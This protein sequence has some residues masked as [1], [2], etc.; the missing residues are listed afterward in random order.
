MLT[1]HETIQLLRGIESVEFVLGGWDMAR[2]S[3]RCCDGRT[4][5]V[6]ESGAAELSSPRPG[7]R[8]T[9][10]EIDP[11]AARARMRRDAGHG[12][13][14]DLEHLAGLSDKS[15]EDYRHRAARRR[16]RMD[17][18]DRDLSTARHMESLATKQRARAEAWR[19]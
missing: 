4:L 5:T 2:V 7:E 17:L 19:A 16:S 10:F 8:R 3:Y 14:A 15:A 13:A 11:E 12:I 1:G 18:R 9:V 6:C